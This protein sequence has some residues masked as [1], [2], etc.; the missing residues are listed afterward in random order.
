M[1]TVRHIAIDSAGLKVFEEGEWKVKKHGSEKR[2]T[3]SKLHL[4]V[5]VDTHE[6]TSAEVSL[7]KTGDNEVLPTLINPL[8]RNIAEL[9]ADGAYY[10]KACHEALKKK[11]IAAIIPPRANT[12]Q[13]EDGHP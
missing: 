9:S 5:D 13:W 10:T 1:V 8:R 4:A 11:K 7:V 3:W 12:G 2:R 6:V